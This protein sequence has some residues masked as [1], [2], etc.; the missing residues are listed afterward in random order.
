[1]ISFRTAFTYCALV[2]VFISGAN[3]LRSSNFALNFA[4]GLAIDLVVA[5][6]VAAAIAAGSRLLAR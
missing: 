2:A 4:G 3:A 6:V 5:L 1:M